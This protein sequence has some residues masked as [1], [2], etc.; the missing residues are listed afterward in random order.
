MYMMYICGFM[1]FD[2]CLNEILFLGKEFG[3]CGVFD[4]DR[5]RIGYFCDFVA[6]YEMVE[7]NG[8]VFMLGMELF[9][10]YEE[11]VESVGDVCVGDVEI[12]FEL[13]CFDDEGFDEDFFSAFAF[14]FVFARE[15]K[16]S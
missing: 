14:F 9:E 6:L 11:Y 5:D 2:E 8:G 10:C 12:Y 13:I 16:L 4:V 3:R 15:L 7:D 1:F